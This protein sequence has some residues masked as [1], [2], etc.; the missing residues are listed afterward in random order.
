M[1]NFQMS[2]SKQDKGMKAE[3]E[4]LIKLT[5]ESEAERKKTV[6]EIRQLKDEFVR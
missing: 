3:L 6:E 2:L 1:A 5:E 4:R